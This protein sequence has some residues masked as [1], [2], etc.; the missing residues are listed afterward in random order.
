MAQETMRRMGFEKLES[1]PCVFKRTCGEFYSFILVY[2]DDLFI[3][4]NTQKAVKRII[5]ELEEL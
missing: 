5:D 4:S 1:A 3:I 2:I